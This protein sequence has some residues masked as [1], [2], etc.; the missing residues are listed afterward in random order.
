MEDD[1]LLLIVGKC[2]HC[3]SEVT[4]RCIVLVRRIEPGALVI[5]R[6]IPLASLEIIQNSIPDTREKI[7]FYIHRLQ[8][9]AVL[10]QFQEDLMKD[11]S[12]LQAV[13]VKA[14]LFAC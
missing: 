12:L 5:E 13:D 6:A 11:G 8:E 1:H 7:G 4:L 2:R 14:Y 10:H 3:T 9:T